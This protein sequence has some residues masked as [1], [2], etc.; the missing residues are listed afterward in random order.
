VR[1]I[2]KPSV[3][4]VRR[5]IEGDIMPKSLLGKV[6]VVFGGLAMLAVVVLAV[7]PFGL[8]AVQSDPALAQKA[9]AAAR[10]AAELH[11]ILATTDGQV[12]ITLDNVPAGSAVE[13]QDRAAAIASTMMSR[14][15]S[16]T[17]VTIYDG[18]HAFMGTFDR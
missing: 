8:G 9:V 4:T 3:A 17:Q 5:E 10:G 16:I 11:D 2:S 12:T 6:G 18:N 13:V 7:H 1:A 14:E 15:P